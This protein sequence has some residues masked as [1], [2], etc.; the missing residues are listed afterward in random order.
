MPSGNAKYTTQ[1]NNKNINALIDIQN[2][3]LLLGSV[4][5]DFD[6]LPII[7]RVAIYAF[8]DNAELINVKFSSGL[9]IIGDFA[10]NSC[11]NLNKVELP[12][13]LTNIANHVFQDCTSLQTI[14]FGGTMTEWNAIIKGNLWNTNVPNT[15]IIYCSDGN[16]YLDG[17]SVD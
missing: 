4:G 10:F 15:C 12:A 14:N 7:Y 3:V 8:V 1:S 5:T 16:L 13:T 17:T 11:D 6:N 2:H 9:A